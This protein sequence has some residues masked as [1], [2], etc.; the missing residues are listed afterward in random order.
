MT[1]TNGRLASVLV[2]A[3][4]CT[5]PR[6]GSPLEVD[7]GANCSRAEIEVIARG[8]GATYGISRVYE[9][10]LDDPRASSFW[11][12]HLGQ[13]Q[14]GRDVFEL[15]HAG[16]DAEGNALPTNAT[17]IFVYDR[18]LLASNL[19]LR[20]GAA[21]GD[22]WLIN[23]DRANEVFELWKGRPDGTLLNGVG[24]PTG[25]FEQSSPIS[26]WD[27]WTRELAFI[28]GRAHVV[29]VL[30]RGGSEPVTTVVLH[31]IVDYYEQAQGGTLGEGEERRFKFPRPCNEEGQLVI[32]DEVEDPTGGESGSKCPEGMH[33]DDI[34]VLATLRTPHA[35]EWSLLLLREVVL[36]EELLDT[37][38]VKI[39]L[40][41]SNTD[42]LNGSLR[43]EAD[44]E[45]TPIPDPN[46]S[47]LAH[48]RLAL[49]LLTRSGNDAEPSVVRIIDDV[50]RGR[51]PLFDTLVLPV[52]ALTPDTRLLQLDGDIALG[53]IEDG[54]WIVTKLFPDAPSRS[55]STVYAAASPIVRVTEAG[56]GAFLLKREDGDADLVRVVCATNDE[57]P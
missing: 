46:R 8:L 32:D 44:L 55:T 10:A 19:S 5:P 25:A 33:Y 1:F 57:D 43:P 18:P 39:T 48:D 14:D 20:P 34:T 24:Y 41:Y 13:S 4:A 26:A 52:D 56:P 21:P 47:G 51:R 16:M 36:D 12:L 42:G 15:V 9:A 37:E 30:R 3:C 31:G 49:Y 53:R 27:E 22:V 2:L 50:I 45:D 28:G 54:Q 40:A 35:P 6:Y 29:G 7:F 17:R 23:H 11:V 38:L